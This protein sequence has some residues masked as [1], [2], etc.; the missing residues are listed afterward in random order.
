MRI[1]VNVTIVTF[2][3]MAGATVLYLDR[4]PVRHLPDRAMTSASEATATSDVSELTGGLD[5][6][7]ISPES[8]PATF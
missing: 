7:K 3:L 2:Y 5:W 8:A 1:S 4:A 6:G